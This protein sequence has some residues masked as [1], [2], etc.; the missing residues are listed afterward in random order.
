M[1]LDI[2]EGEAVVTSICMAS[3]FVLSLYM[4]IPCEKKNVTKQKVYNENSREEIL[5]RIT[6]VN[7]KCVIF[8]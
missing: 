6:S 3:F 2:G 7:L 1:K 4:W 5:K 8:H